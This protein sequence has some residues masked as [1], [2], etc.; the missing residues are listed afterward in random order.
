MVHNSFFNFAFQVAVLD[1]SSSSVLFLTDSV[2][3]SSSPVISLGVKSFPNT[4]NSINSL[5]DSNLDTSENPTRNVVF[6]MTKDGHIVVCDS[7]TG[8]ILASQSLHLK[9][10]SAISM[11]IL[12]E[13]F[14]FKEN[15]LSIMPWNC[16]FLLY[17]CRG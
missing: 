2:S 3:D 1:I 15:K 17:L 9:E 4:N 16:N 13:S 7:T 5:K 11:Y 10:S 8:K 6:F 14:C 12:G